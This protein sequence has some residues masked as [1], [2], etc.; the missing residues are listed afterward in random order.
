[1]PAHRPYILLIQADQHRADCLGAAGHP[2]L[3][4]PHLDRL[5]REGV[6][7]DHAFTP[8]PVCVPARVSLAHGQWP[9]S[10]LA[11]ANWGTE[12][13]R[14]AREGLPD[15]MTQLHEAGYRLAHVGKWHVHPERGPL[16]YGFDED[17]PASEYAAWRAGRRLPPAP[18]HPD[19]SGVLD[20]GIDPAETRPAWQAAEVI[21]LLEQGAAQDR[22]LY[23]QW[24]LDEP[25]LPA[26]LPEPYYSLYPP[27][28]IDPWPGYPDPLI[29]KPYAQGQQRRS[30]QVENWTWREWA[31]V[32]ARY[33]GTLSL[34]DA[35]VGRV[36]EALDRLGLAQETLV[37]YT[38]DHGD[39]CGAH[40]MFDK[41]MVMYDDITRVPLLVRWPGT[42]PA[43]TT[44]EAFVSHA[45]DLAVT[46]CQAAGVPVP[47]AFQGQ[48]L[49][50]LLSGE[51]PGRTDILSMY[52]G[53]QF[54]LYSERMLRDARYKYVWNA[55]A[56][57]EL[58]DLALDPG[59]VHNLDLD[60]AY[61]DER[62]HLRARLVT[63]MESIA[64]P[65][66][67]SWTRRQLLEE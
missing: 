26:V 31:P 40:G 1:M 2:L 59:E 32:V 10:H 35:H 66:L 23:V 15:Y 14:P 39:M 25:H 38:S 45:L 52:H 36:L 61:R 17:V 13:P 67:N 51:A 43:G 63:W 21:R 62:R 65:L 41:H 53:N 50:P 27:E 28:T 37:V 42:T 64:D 12:A 57:D 6:R 24:D 58:Y 22:P 19:W 7:F 56:E 29:G 34:I 20:A 47:A 11:I 49:L 9:T 54:G 60:P 30:W 46:F 44:H 48:S 5:A 8:I 55:A 18:R 3:Q 16:A 4:T 33:L